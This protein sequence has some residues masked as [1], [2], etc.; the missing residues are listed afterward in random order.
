MAFQ[1][2]MGVTKT[3]AAAVMSLW[4]VGC[5]GAP[6]IPPELQEK[7][8]RDVSFRQISALPLSYKGKLIA[9]GGIVLSVKLKQDGTHIEILQLPLTSDHEPQ[10]RLIDSQGRFLAYH[11]ELLDPAT[12][13][14]GTRVTVVGE[15]TGSTTRMLDEIG[16]AYPTVAITSLT[17][18]PS[19]LPPCWYRSYPYFDV[20]WGRYW[21]P[22]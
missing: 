15:I 10:G 18:W 1:S 2:V 8:E 7:I 21:R 4:I 16:Y 6:V 3:V 22:Y 9:A 13:P 20:Y 14:T 5:G 19:M 12:I 17:I 11:R